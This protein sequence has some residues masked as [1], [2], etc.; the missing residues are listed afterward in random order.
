MQCTQGTAQLLDLFL[1]DALAG[2]AAWR[3]G[4]CTD[5]ACNDQSMS[6]DQVWQWSTTCASVFL[7]MFLHVAEC[8]LN[9]YFCNKSRL[10]RG[11]YRHFEHC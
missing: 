3:S 10:C 6:Y 7:K 1:E 2:A 9:Y 5:T 8:V 11:I 4:V